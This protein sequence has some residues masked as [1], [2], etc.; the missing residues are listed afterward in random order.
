[1]WGITYG[2]LVSGEA[3]LGQDGFAQARSLDGKV[4]W[5]KQFGTQ[6]TDIVKAIAV[7]SEGTV[8]VGGTTN[9]AFAGMLDPVRDIFLVRIEQ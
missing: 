4:L 2:E 6:K 1:M 8:Y 5:T 9:G 7:N 3:Q